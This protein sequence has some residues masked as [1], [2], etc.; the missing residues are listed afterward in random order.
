MY[1]ADFAGNWM[2]LSSIEILP[3][4]IF[5]LGK[6]STKKKKIHIKP[7]DSNEPFGC[8]MA[9]HVPELFPSQNVDQLLSNVLSVKQL[10]LSRASSPRFLPGRILESSH[11]W[12]ARAQHI[13]CHW[14]GSGQ[15]RQFQKS[16]VQVPV[17]G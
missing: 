3:E 16:L 12:L 1:N 6:P 9:W 17:A 15:H 4:S 5:V 14:S 10:H 13:A 7:N 2:C 8:S 11:L